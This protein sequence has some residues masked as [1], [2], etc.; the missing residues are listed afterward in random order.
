VE[1][2]K[3]PQIWSEHIHYEI[4]MLHKVRELREREAKKLAEQIALAK[5]AA[6]SELSVVLNNVLVEAFLVHVRN[7]VEFFRGR[8][9]NQ[10]HTHVSDFLGGVAQTANWRK[11]KLSEDDEA[12]LEA[13]WT[14]ASTHLQHPSRL[15]TNDATA[16]PVDFDRD[17]EFFDRLM[18]SFVSS[19]AARA[20]LSQNVDWSP[21]DR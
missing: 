9:T 5:I 15:R 10:D 17:I 3:G 19:K 6:Y 8:K 20:N 4:W 13:L 12:R 2:Q 11:A 16:R 18:S 14:F 21:W 7:L 1:Y